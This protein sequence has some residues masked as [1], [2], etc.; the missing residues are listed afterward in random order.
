MDRKE[1]ISIVPMIKVWET[2]L[3]N[4]SF[5]SKMI[6]S[7]S[8]EEVISSLQETPYGGKINGG[9]FETRL[10]DSFK[11]LCDDLN[12]T[13]KNNEI[14][15]FVRLKNDYHNLKTLIKAK[16]LNKDFSYMLNT[17]GTMPIDKLEKAIRNENYRDISVN[18]ENVIKE[19]F[20]ELDT[21]K[22]SQVID[23][24]V[25]RYMFKDMVSIAK[26]IESAYISKYVKTVIDLTNIKTVLRLKKINKDKAFLSYVFIEDGTIPLDVCKN[27][28]LDDFD[29]MSSRL[30]V[31]SYETVVR[32]VIDDYS[33]SKS[34]S[35]LEKRF[36]DYIM[37]YV[38]DAKFINFGVEPVFAYL[39]AREIEIK[40]LR[41]ILAGKI[42]KVDSE[43]INERLRDN[44][45]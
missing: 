39:Y 13:I 20:L 27:M 3:L 11:D 41:I 9:N 38:R 18:I 33:E 14:I 45:V 44:Y 15:D 8:L 28:L 31:T 12:K 21:K 7:N 36:D 40:N 5:Y 37:A 25:D 6:N 34:L 1:F 10:D 24:V 29:N 2:K 30:G 22:D 26:K 23:I 19:V 32:E 17:N 35:S 42:N 43:I 4:K 16:V